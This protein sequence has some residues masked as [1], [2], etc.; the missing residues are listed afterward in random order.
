MT[1]PPLRESCVASA[2]SFHTHHADCLTVSYISG[3]SQ[4]KS[5]VFPDLCWLL[6]QQLSCFVAGKQI[7]RHSISQSTLQVLH[8]IVPAAPQAD[9]SW[10]SDGSIQVTLSLLLM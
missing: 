3:P 6:S 10:D 7:G 8:D 5:L 1:S 2:C 9:M 4:N